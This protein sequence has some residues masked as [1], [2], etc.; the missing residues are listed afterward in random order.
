MS[1]K[2][3]TRITIAFPASLNAVNYLRNC[4]GNLANECPSLDDM[5][6]KRVT[7][8]SAFPAQFKVPELVSQVCDSIKYTFETD[9]GRWTGSKEKP[10]ICDILKL[11]VFDSNTHECLAQKEWKPKHACEHVIGR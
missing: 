9:G 4:C 5:D 2:F 10:F 3:V 8:W 11:E 6:W 7:E 1:M